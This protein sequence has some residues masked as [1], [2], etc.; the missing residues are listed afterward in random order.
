MTALL[1]LSVAFVVV[2]YVVAEDELAYE[3]KDLTTLFFEKNKLTE[4]T[5]HPPQPMLTCIDHHSVPNG[6]NNTDFDLVKCTKSH[7]ESW[8]KWGCYGIHTDSRRCVACENVIMRVVSLNCDSALV[9]S[10]SLVYT[11]GES[12]ES[13]LDDLCTERILFSWSTW[14]ILLIL[15]PS[16]SLIMVFGVVVVVSLMFPLECKKCLTYLIRKLEKIEPNEEK[17]KRYD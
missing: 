9:K 14:F 1:I 6:C 12:Y 5:Q 8:D 11:F 3:I 17:Q 7:D 10:C 4:S 16:V 15:V 13:W 2:V